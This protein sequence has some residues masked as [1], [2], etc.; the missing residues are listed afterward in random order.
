MHEFAHGELKSGPGG[1]GGKVKSRKQAIEIALSEAGAS[2]YQITSPESPPPAPNWRRGGNQNG[3]WWTARIR[4][5][6]LSSVLNTSS[7]SRR[8]ATASRLMI[9]LTC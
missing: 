9:A 2:N 3:A 4:H 7:F 8:R 1:K 6:P 5:R